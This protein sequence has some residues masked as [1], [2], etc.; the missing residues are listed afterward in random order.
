MTMNVDQ[1]MEV[2][3]QKYTF[4]LEFR[5]GCLFGAGFVE[6]ALMSHKLGVG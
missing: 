5:K 3:P 2:P 4:F 1:V 6:I